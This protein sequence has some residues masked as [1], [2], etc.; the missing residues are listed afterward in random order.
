MEFIKPDENYF[1]EYLS[2]CRESY[3]NNIITEWMPVEL[4]DLPV[5]KRKRHVCLQYWKAGDG[6]S[7][8]VPQMRTYWCIENSRFVGRGPNPSASVY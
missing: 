3:D 7:T 4:K 8:G 6:L 1:D 5:G 2:A